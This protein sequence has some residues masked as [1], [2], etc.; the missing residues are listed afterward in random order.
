MQSSSKAALYALYKT[1]LKEQV[2]IFEEFLFLL[3]YLVNPS[4]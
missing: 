2:L 4:G 1:F 3:Y